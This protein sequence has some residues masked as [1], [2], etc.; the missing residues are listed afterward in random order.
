M[1]KD[2]NIHPA[3]EQ[4]LARADHQLSSECVPGPYC[5]PL[6]KAKVVL[7]FLSPGLDPSD[8]AHGASQEGRKYYAEQRT[9]EAM[10]PDAKQHESA[11]KWLTSAI[12]QF[13]LDYE[14]ARSTVATLNIGAYKSKS[15]P[16]WPM[17]AALPSSRVSLSWAQSVLFPKAERGET[18]V[19]CLRSPNHWGLGIGDPIGKSLFRPKCTRSARM[20][21]KGGMREHIVKT[22]QDAVRGVLPAIKNES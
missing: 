18:V 20:E 3:D 4:V 13:G 9:G 17:L 2:A 5:G 10:L 14:E 8:I 22:V 11:Q 21:H 16:D 12:K 1:P 7:L 19:V 6:K 15:F